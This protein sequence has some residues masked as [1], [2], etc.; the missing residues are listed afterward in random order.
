MSSPKPANPRKDDPWADYPEETV[1]KKPK[2]VTPDHLTHRPFQD[3]DELQALRH[4]LI[5]ALRDDR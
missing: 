1:E 2:Y 4:N 3:S 5:L